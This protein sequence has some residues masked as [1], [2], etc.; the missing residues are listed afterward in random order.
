MQT[1]QKFKIT[2]PANENQ[3]DF[4]QQHKQAKHDK[5]PPSFPIP[6]ICLPRE[7]AKRYL[8]I[9]NGGETCPERSRMD[10]WR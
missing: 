8:S 10:P 2:T 6:L 7:I 1:S 3:A 5:L 4:L 9:Y